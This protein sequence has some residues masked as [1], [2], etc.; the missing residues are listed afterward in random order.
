MET[1]ENSKL[2]KISLLLFI[3]ISLGYG[4]IYLFFPEVEIKAAGGDPIPPGWIRWFG[5]ILIPLGVAAIMIFRNPSKQGIFIL[6]VAIGNL[7][8]GLTLFYTVSFE[9]EGIG[10]LWH[11]IIPAIV[12]IMLSILF[13]ISLNKSKAILW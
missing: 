4:V 6:M 11:T 7:L 10:N 9:S 12:H 3:V 8:V 2:L 1:N 5:A 13:W